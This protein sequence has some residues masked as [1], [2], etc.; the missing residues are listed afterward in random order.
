MRI[1]DL[2]SAPSPSFSFEFFAP[3][4]DDGK[5]A[6]KAALDEL[7]ELSPGFI[8]ITCGAAGSRR[9]PSLELVKELMVDGRF[10]VMAHL[11][12]Q[13]QTK[14]SLE[15]DLA[16]MNRLGVE[17][18]F[19][20]RGDPPKDE[21]IHLTSNDAPQSGAD[22][23][24]MVAAKRKFYVGAA[25]YPD[26]HPKAAS[27]V[28]GVE[29]LKRKEEAGA[30]FLITQLFFDNNRFYDFVNQVRQADI[31]LPI[32]PGIMPIT[33]FK[34]VKRFQETCGVRVPDRLA[35]VLANHQNNSAAIADFGVAFATAQCIDL[36]DHG[37][38]HLHFFTLNRSPATRAIVLAL[39]NF[40]ASPA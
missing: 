38:R 37:F 26:V 39:K 20:L 23:V 1:L 30:R 10:Q 35:K 29:D 16:L 34:Q 36:M 17:N 28:A 24:R 15:R 33:S 22:F 19:A 11:T 4:D 5:A 40:T 12:C 27:S 9:Q 8:S 32:I 25:A 21:L 14:A 18:I 3:K 13:G 2:L 7:I 6:F 31:R